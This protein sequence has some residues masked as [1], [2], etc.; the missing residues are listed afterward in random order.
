MR[1]WNVE[2]TPLG[3]R[4]TRGDGQ[5][6][7]NILKRSHRSLTLWSLKR[8]KPQQLELLAKYKS[9]SAILDAIDRGQY[10]VAGHYIGDEINGTHLIAL[11]DRFGGRETLIHE[12]FHFFFRNFLDDGQIR[13]ILENFESE[14]HAA[15]WY[16]QEFLR[17]IEK[18][19]TGVNPPPPPLNNEQQVRTVFQYIKD[20]ADKLLQAMKIK[21]KNK[22]EAYVAT[23]I[24]DILMDFAYGESSK[25]PLLGLWQQSSVRTLAGVR[26]KRYARGRPAIYQGPFTEIIGIL[27]EAYTTERIMDTAVDT[28][29]MPP[30]F[31]LVPVTEDIKKLVQ[32]YRRRIR[33]SIVP[34]ENISPEDYGMHMAM[35]GGDPNYLVYRI[36]REGGS[37]EFLI[38]DGESVSV[39]A[40][41]PEQAAKALA[42][43]QTLG[44]AEEFDPD[45]VNPVRPND[46]IAQVMYQMEAMSGRVAVA[47]AFQR[48][49]SNNLEEQSR[50]LDKAL[51]IEKPSDVTSEVE[52]L[53]ADSAPKQKGFKFL[54]TSFDAAKRM[55]KWDRKK[56]KQ[57]FSLYRGVPKDLYVTFMLRKRGVQAGKYFG[58]AARKDINRIIKALK[59]KHGKQRVSNALSMV[60]D[61]RMPLEQFKSIYDLDDTSPLMKSL[62]DVIQDKIEMQKQ[63][64]SMPNIPQ[65]LKEIILSNDYY[66]TRVYAIHVL[67]DGYIPTQAAYQ[68][69]STAVR[70]YYEQHLN[71]Q[72]KK[73]MKAVGVKEPFDLATYLKSGVLKRQEM[74]KGLAKTRQQAIMSVA[75]GLDPWMDAIESM[76]MV[77]GNFVATQN[78]DSLMAIAEDTVRAYV[79]HAQSKNAAQTMGPIRGVP[80]AHLLPQKLDAVFRELY[81]EITHPA[82][83]MARTIE[84]QHDLLAASMFFQK[85][86]EEG[87]NA[88]W[89]QTRRGEFQRRLGYEGKDNTM[90]D[91][92][93]RYG[94]MAGMYVTQETYDLLHGEGAFETIADKTALGR[95]FQT[96]QSLVRGT[97]LLWVKTM[98]RNA[99]TSVFGFALRSG[100]MLYKT[101]TGHFVEGWKLVWK[102]GIVRDPQAVRMM[103]RLVQDDVFDVSQDSILAA[104]QANMQ[105]GAF[106]LFG[107]KGAGKAG[108]QR[109]MEIY[110]LIDLPAKYAAYQV[111]VG[112][113]GLS[114]EKA[115]EHVRR[116]YQYRDFVPEIVS[117]MNRWPIGDYFGYTVD[118]T[119]I[120]V[121]E[122]KHVVESG[123]DKNIRPLIGFTLGLTT[124]LFRVGAGG[125]LAAVAPTFFAE[126][127]ARGTG[128]AAKY[129]LG[130]LLT[131]LGLDDDD[132]EKIKIATPEEMTAIRKALALYDRGMPLAAWYEKNDETGMWD[133]KLRYLSNAGA[134]PLEDVIIGAIQTA[135]SAPEGSKAKAFGKALVLNLNQAAPWHLGMA[136]ENISKLWSGYDPSTG[137]KR[138]GLNDVIISTRMPEEA[139][140]PDWPDVFKE[141]VGDFLGESVLPGQSWNAVRAVQEVIEGRQPRIGSLQRRKD[142]E[143][144]RDLLFRLVRKHDYQGEDQL[145]M[146]RQ[147]TRHSFENLGISKWMAGA[148]TRA[149]MKYAAEQF[150]EET[151]QSERGR[152]AWRQSLKS[153][154][155]KVQ[156]FKVFTRGN[157]H[158]DQIVEALT[159]FGTIRIAEAEAVVNGTVDQMEAK[160]YGAGEEPYATEPR[161]S[162]PQRGQAFANEYFRTH[163]GRVSYRELYRMM[164][165]EGYVVD[166]KFSDF[167]KDAI[168]WRRALR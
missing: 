142:A 33:L 21:P 45:A 60:L 128:G 20:L 167:K 53:E 168:R 57:N 12:A 105:G 143:E 36:G 16:A 144:V 61:G 67:G 145:Y 95:V 86:F 93:K 81:G 137:Q 1:G 79:E 94:N 124:P 135:A 87:E 116:F 129:V 34:E 162:R 70:D 110:A 151:L 42:Q 49:V 38:H 99:L 13:T 157:F 134:F 88:W 123:Q 22:S 161:P 98:S 9:A 43:A 5:V 48:G 82:D 30:G 65:E 117:K 114:H 154:E 66:Q 122:M 96:Y 51:G 120:L 28:D 97:R 89:S 102:A 63:L 106:E 10:G 44:F 109:A 92:K 76:E 112:E 156:D 163:P 15:R 132:D 78:A 152:A 136:F 31:L 39:F 111:A 23:R 47:D 7:L 125:W 148:E 75:R 27:T 83:R 150:R 3:W 74:L 52:P 146:L 29:A 40:E 118:S 140:R 127:V 55:V 121:E 25:S 6:V 115:V 113:R 131:A 100:D 35:G 54:A 84:V 166:E 4:V 153:L 104:M 32:D 69:A 80:I 62:N 149:E 68:N 119:R 2:A 73:A 50:H 126:S 72:I 37:A 26:S 58:I 159:E 71:D 101:W 139:A 56:F 165:D 14:E 77:D 155:A 108:F 103:A 141:R 64:A 90:I 17:I 158:D 59:S 130:N 85:M 91:A 160:A 11:S 138:P 133:L 24:D 41:T 18:E 107:L 19:E 147:M 46:P 8:D 164:K